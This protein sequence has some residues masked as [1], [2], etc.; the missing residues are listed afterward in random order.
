ML[1]PGSGRTR[2]PPRQAGAATRFSP[3]AGMP[4]NAAFAAATM[5]SGST[6]PAT[7]TMVFAAVYCCR[8]QA[9]SS[10]RVNLRMLARVPITGRAAGCAPKQARSNCLN[11]VAIASSSSSAYS[12][13]MTLRSRSSSAFG[14]AALAHDV[15]QH[16]D[17]CHGVPRQAAHVEGGVI[18]VGVGV[19][20]GA[21]ALGVEV[22]L[23]AVAR[24]RALEGH[25]LDDVADAVQACAFVLAAAAHEHADRRGRQMRQADDNDARAVV[26]RGDQ[27]VRI[28]SSGADVRHATIQD[29]VAAIREVPAGRQCSRG[30]PP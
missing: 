14:N 23:L 10:A 20:L 2:V 17:A 25:V 27:G 24:T 8:T 6:L 12:W 30:A 9:T 29:E 16:A 28:A 26:E 13:R 4:P 5:S 11:A 18:L 15:A 3:P 7:P 19:D 22:D 21:Q 1:D